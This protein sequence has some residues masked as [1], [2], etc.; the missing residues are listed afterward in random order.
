MGN[1]P[2]FIT[3][4]TG[5]GPFATFRFQ[6]SDGQILVEV[7]VSG[8]KIQYSEVYR[9]NRRYEFSLSGA[10][11]LSFSGILAGFRNGKP[12]QGFFLKD[13]QGNPVE[14]LMKFHPKVIYFYL[15]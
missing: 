9:L 6:E 1:V 11:T 13:I 14:A 7:P 12:E 8:T 15:V 10:G 2:S 3:T 5:G 4:F